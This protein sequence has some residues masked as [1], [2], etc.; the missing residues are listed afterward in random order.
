MVYNNMNDENVYNGN[1]VHYIT[2]QFNTM[3]YLMLLWVAC[4]LELV[5]LQPQTM[6]VVCVCVIY[7]IFSFR[8][9]LIHG[10]VTLM[11]SLV[12]ASGTISGIVNGTSSLV[13]GTVSG[14][15]GTVNGTSSMVS[16]TVNGTSNMVSGASGTVNGTSSMVSGASGTVNGTSNMVSGTVNGTSGIVSGTNGTVSGTSDGG[17]GQGAVEVGEGAGGLKVCH[18][19]PRPPQDPLSGHQSLHPHRAPGVDASSADTNLSPQPKPVAIGET[20]AG[21]VEDT[22]TVH[23]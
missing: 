17:G 13:S 2:I 21:I 9:S 7:Y 15:S 11:L 12:Y 19:V 5:A 6:G 20:S 4:V 1:S 3:Q 23:R 22:R 18:S 16:G 10:L 14:A 8:I